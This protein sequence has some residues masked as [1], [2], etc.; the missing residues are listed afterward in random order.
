MV[1]MANSNKSSL[2]VSFI[3][4]SNAQ[5]VLAVWVAD[6]PDSMLE[7]FNEEA[8]NVTFQL[9]PEYAN[10]QQ[11]VHVRITELPIVDKIRDLRSDEKSSLNCSNACII[12]VDL[13]LTFE[14][15]FF[16]FFS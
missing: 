15:S 8:T 13:F 14:C 5:P 6:E 1:D 3:H 16:P 10:I 9:Y 4:L 11:S 2:E 7:I 12:F